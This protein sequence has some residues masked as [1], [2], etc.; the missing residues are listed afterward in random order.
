MLKAGKETKQALY[1]FTKIFEE[2][3]G[4]PLLLNFYHLS[5]RQRK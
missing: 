2:N 3:Y 1:F 4:I 5:Y